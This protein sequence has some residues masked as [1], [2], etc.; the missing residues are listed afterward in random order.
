MPPLHALT[1]AE[2]ARRIRDGSLT[3]ERLTS[4]FLGRI[5]RLNPNLHAFVEV[6]PETALA[7]ARVADAELARRHDRGPLHGIP[8]A[9][10]DIID[11]EGY[12]TRCQSRAA[13]AEA[14]TRDSHVAARLKAAGA[15]LLG[16]LNTWEYALDGPEDG[17]PDPPA[18]NP[19]SLAHDPGG[20]SSGCAAAVAAGLVRLT[21]GTDTGGSIRYPSALCGV[22]GLKPT[23]G[24]V[25]RSGIFPVAPSLDHC[26]PI[27][28]TVDEAAALFE[29]MAGF[30]RDDPSSLP[31]PH[32][33]PPRAI[34][35]LRVGVVAEEADPAFAP[36]PEQRAALQRAA[37]SLAA[38]G[39]EVVQARLPAYDRWNACGIAILLAEAFA[40]HEAALRRVSDRYGDLVYR[41]LV[42]GATLTAADLVQAHR[43]RR[44]LADTVG[45]ALTCFDV[46]LTYAALAP[47]PALGAPGR[48]P[49]YTIQFDVSGHPAIAIPM[50]LSRDRLPLGIELCGPALGE[51]T[52]FAAAA[53]IEADSRWPET[54]MTNAYQKSEVEVRDR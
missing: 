7:A 38:R 33:L 13:S 42:S 26:G 45:E 21:V 44:E 14:K 28:A 12:R 8:Y 31:G 52:L 54:A 11:A 36:H 32:G 19:W 24:A 22:V 15:V 29:A 1:T 51:P 48:P 25:G 30:D 27:A 35:G 20:S 4:H 50:G 3:S 9:L 53:A 5:A 39:A 10:K 49:A 43:L 17:L 34:D 47:A 41:G 18:R 37:R 46:L 23:F 40:V 6:R 16:K 2:A